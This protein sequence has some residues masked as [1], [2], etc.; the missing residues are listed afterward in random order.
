MFGD[1][2]T[3]ILQAL[4]RGVHI[5]T[6]DAR[7]P[8]AGATFDVHRVR[9]RQVYVTEV[10]GNRLHRGEPGAGWLVAAV[11]VAVAAAPQRR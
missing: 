5:E 7:H 11:K 4:P 6:R 10:G 1:L 9:W 8:R 2:E 3:G